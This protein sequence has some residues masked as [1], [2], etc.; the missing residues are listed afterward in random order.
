MRKEPLIE[1]CV[2]HVFTKSIAGFKV[3]RGKREYDRFIEMMQF[4]EHESPPVKFSYYAELDDKDIYY[5]TKIKPNPCLVEIIAYCVMPTHIHLILKQLKENGITNFLRPLLDSYTRYFNIRND[6]KGPLWQSRFKSVLVDNDEY[7][8]H[9]TR[10]IHLNPVSD[11]LVENPEDWHYSSYR[12]YIN[13]EMNG[14]CN[15]SSYIN[16]KPE[17]YKEF[18][19]SRKD[20]QK[21][22]AAIKH[23]L[24]E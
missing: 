7:L 21:F 10:Y 15:F 5:E 6:R 17:E 12:E 4:Y 24:L 9:L 1:G 13:T 3:F 2:Y 20:Y 23:L 16:L 14:L 19:E 22:L 11:S 8:L 18:V